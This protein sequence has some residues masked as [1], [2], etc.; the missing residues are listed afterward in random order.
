VIIAF[1]VK[2]LCKLVGGSELYKIL[3]KVH[4]SFCIMIII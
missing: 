1:F 4:N 2:S 3:A